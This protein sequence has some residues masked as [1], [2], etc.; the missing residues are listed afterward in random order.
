MMVVMLGLLALVPSLRATLDEVFWVIV[1][2]LGAYA[3]KV[4]IDLLVA[5][6]RVAAHRLPL[7][8]LVQAQQT[9]RRRLCGPLSPD[10]TQDR[11]AH[12]RICRRVQLLVGQDRID[13]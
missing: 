9:I 5:A 6:A 10:P 1:L 13:R 2:M 7:L 12:V 4:L 11:I 3:F 8:R